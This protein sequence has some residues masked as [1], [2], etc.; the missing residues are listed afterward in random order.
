MESFDVES[1]RKHGLRGSVH[2][3]PNIPIAIEPILERISIRMKNRFLKT[4]LLSDR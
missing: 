2:S 4:N 1:I 3:V